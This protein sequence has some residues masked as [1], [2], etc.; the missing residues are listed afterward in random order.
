MSRHEVL[1]AI[2][3]LQECNLTPSEAIAVVRVAKVRQG[4]L[5][6]ELPA[7]LDLV[8]DDL[9]QQATVHRFVAG[10]LR[11]EGVEMVGLERAA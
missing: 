3:R 9:E 5:M 11:S 2:S 7:A 4:P 6:V 10:R 1:A 8:A